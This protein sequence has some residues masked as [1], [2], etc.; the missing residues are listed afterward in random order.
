M[1]NSEIDSTNTNKSEPRVRFTESPAPY[2]GN[3]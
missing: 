3:L 2:A 1:D